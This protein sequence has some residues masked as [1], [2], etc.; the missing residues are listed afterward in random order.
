MHSSLSNEERTIIS[1]QYRALIIA[2]L[3]F[4]VSVVVLRSVFHGTTKY[5]MVLTILP[6][7]YIAFSSMKHRVSILRLRGQKGYSRGQRALLLGTILLI[8]EVATL[9]FFLSP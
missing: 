3:I 5:A 8:V 9:I 2:I 1:W 7:F 6:M 4:I